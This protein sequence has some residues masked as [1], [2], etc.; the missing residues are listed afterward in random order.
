MPPPSEVD[1][2]RRRIAIVSDAWHPQIN[3]VVRTL[4]KVTA[5]LRAAG[6]QVLVIGPD[7]FCTMPCPF[8]PEIRL[9]LW[10]RQRLAALLA[11]FAPDSIHIATEGP[12]GLAA[13]SLARRAGW[14]FTTAYHTHFP[15]YLAA[16]LR[17]PRALTYRWLRR[18]HGRSVSVMV[19]TSGLAAELAARGFDNT[20]LWSRGVDLALFHPGNAAPLPY[21]RP[22]FLSVGRL[23]VE[24]NL[25]AFLGL[26]LPGSKLVIGDGPARAALQRAYPAAH[27]LG[28]L[29]GEALAQA[30]ASSDVFVFPSETDTF[31]L[32]LLEA[33]ASGLPV[34]AFPAAAPRAVLGGAALGGAAP[35][36]GALD[37]DLEAAARAALS[38]DRSACRRFAEGF[39]WAASA[40]QF[41]ENLVPLIPRRS[42]AA[43]PRPAASQ[44]SLPTPTTHI[45]ESVP[46]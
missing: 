17:L 6:H 19:A 28:A 41:L 39:S 43:A 11:A 12:L 36:V 22:I 30:Y 34:A 16:R 8:Y 4:A 44:Q 31:G 33:L 35:P 14:A 45:K 26:D 20:V 25:P 10:P 3:G 24:K 27:F 42:G 7:R 15:D 37:R 5:E 32:V 2:A 29:Q 9:A 40:R 38:L 13:A 18:F 46:C 23:A 21:P 1:P